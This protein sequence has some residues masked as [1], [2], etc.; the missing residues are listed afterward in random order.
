MILVLLSMV[1][2]FST[3]E[4]ENICNLRD[5]TS[6]SGDVW[7]PNFPNNYPTL[8][9]CSFVISVPFGKSVVISFKAMDLENEEDEN[10][11]YDVVEIE[12]LISGDKLARCGSTIPSDITTKGNQVRIS[13]TSDFSDAGNRKPTGFR[14][15]YSTISNIRGESVC[16]GRE[17]TTNKEGGYVMSPN[18]PLNY[19]NNI[20]CIFS[21]LV[22][23]GKKTHIE[24]EEMNIEFDNRCANDRLNISSDAGQTRVICGE[25][26]PRSSVFHGSKVNFHFLT[27][28]QNTK[29]GFLIKYY[30]TK[31]EIYAIDCVCP[32]GSSFIRVD[33]TKKKLIRHTDDIRFEF[34]TRQ[35]SSLLLHAMGKHRDFLRVKLIRGQLKFSVD[36][37]TGK[38]TITVPSPALN[39]NRWHYVEITRTGRRVKVNVDRQVAGIVETPGIF[40]KLDLRAPNA[41][42]YVAG[43]ANRNHGSNFVGCLKNFIIDNNRPIVDALRGDPAH[44]IFFNPFPKCPMF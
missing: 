26:K 39:D 18:Y 12:D 10:S 6:Q 33:L 34:K 28:G 25:G 4:G 43:S 41:Y 22:P 21:L 36:L 5:T 32:V 44:A 37:G 24:F 30:F 31:D 23:Q 11:C 8:Q 19:G 29:K 17:F 2:F 27:N 16:P 35:P 1:F 20:N 14:L 40:T 13:F 7:S 38:G 9:R 3:V 15:T 42:M